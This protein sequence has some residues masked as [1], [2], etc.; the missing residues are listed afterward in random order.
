VLSAESYRESAPAAV[1]EA[2]GLRMTCLTTKPGIQFYSGNFMT[3]EIGKGG[4]VYAG[5]TGL[6]LETQYW[7]NF[8]N[9]PQF[10]APILRKGEVYNHFTAYRFEQL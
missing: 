10:P 3:G 2:G 6:C 8:V 7:P 1:L 4:A 5:R 9:R